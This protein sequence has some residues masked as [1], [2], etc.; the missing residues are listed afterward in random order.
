MK[1]SLAGPPIT[2]EAISEFERQFGKKLPDDIRLLL[3]QETNGGYQEGY[4]FLPMDG[5]G[6]TEITHLYGIG[7]PEPVFDMFTVLANMDR[8]RTDELWP[9][10]SDL[11]GGQF[12]LILDGH[13]KGEIHNMPDDSFSMGMGYSGRVAKDMQEFIRLLNSPSLPPPF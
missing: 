9:F 4:F 1:W 6:A 5:D 3:E 7:H 12:V 11:S 8:D 2:G 13:R 10:G